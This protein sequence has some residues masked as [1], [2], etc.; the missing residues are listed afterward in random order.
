MR[1]IYLPEIF[2]LK[3]VQLD[4]E[5]C[6]HF[7][8]VLKVKDGEEI[9]LLD[10]RGLRAQGALVFVGKKK[11]RIDLSGEVTQGI[12]PEDI[13]VVVGQTKKDAQDLV[14]KNLCELGVT[15]IIITHSQFAQRYKI[16]KER[17][18]KQ[19]ISALEQSNNL[20]LPDFEMKKLDEIDWDSFTHTYILSTEEKSHSPIPPLTAGCAIV[21]GPEGGFGAE[22]YQI[23]KAMTH[24]SFLNIKSPILRTPNAVSCAVGYLWGVRDA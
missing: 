2:T 3:S 8:N 16:N 19:L 14:I 15:K 1:A 6:H 13:T 4:E 12:P 17:V 5:K 10:G 18:K 21:V 22:D 23:F 20:F 24:A 9:L 11:L 7:K